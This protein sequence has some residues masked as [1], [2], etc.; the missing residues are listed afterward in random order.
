MHILLS[1]G[2]GLI[3]S[4]LCK[5]WHA[6]G[7][8]LTVW[9]RRPEGV[10]AQCGKDVRAVRTL[11]E[12]PEAPLDAIVNLA[13]APIVDQR[14]TP[15]RKQLLRDSRV[16]VTEQFVNWLSRRQHRPPVFISAS[17]IGYYGDNKARVLD[18]SCVP[19]KTDFASELCQ[20]WEAAAQGVEALDVRLIRL[21][22]GLVLAPN[23][24]LFKRLLLPFRCG[25]GGPLG[26][27]QHWMSWI[28]IKDQIRLMDF[29]LHTPTAQGVYNACSPAPVRNSDFTRA[30]GQALQRPAVLRVP[31]WLLRTILGEAAELLLSSQRVMP[32]RLQEAGFSFLFTDL[33]QA[34][35]DLLKPVH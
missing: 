23:G 11:A 4:V 10:R 32:A 1:G 15:P 24:G 2:T 22:I 28:H 26:D 12:V 13:G 34:L 7:H 25:L 33:E 3:G 20:A 35:E 30:L 18:E 31:A 27:G 6:Q 29:L 5:Y 19:E 9:S 14:W 21:R 17:A 16:G 8:D